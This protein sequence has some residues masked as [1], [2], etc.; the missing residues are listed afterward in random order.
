MM[1]G[2]ISVAV[3]FVSLSGKYK[4]V[5]MEKAG[6]SGLVQIFRIKTKTKDGRNI[7]D[8]NFY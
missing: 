5:A 1:S 3:S 4:D 6:R 2:L 7:I 8:V